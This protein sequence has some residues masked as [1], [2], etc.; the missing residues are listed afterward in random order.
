MRFSNFILV[1]EKTKTQCFENLEVKIVCLGKYK[2][3]DLRRLKLLES[4]SLRYLNE[5]TIDENKR[6]NNGQIMNKLW[7]ALIKLINF[8]LNILTKKKLQLI[9]PSVDCNRKQAIMFRSKNSAI[10]IKNIFSAI[11]IIPIKPLMGPPEGR[12]ERKPNIGFRAMN[13]KSNLG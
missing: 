4:G 8:F 11:F 5:Q 10:C 12:H 13:S 3:T 7:S 2:V 6:T 1:E 9:M